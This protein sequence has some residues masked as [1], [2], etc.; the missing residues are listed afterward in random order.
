MY[1]FE[2]AYIYSLLCYLP[3]LSCVP[4]VHAFLLLRIHPSIVWIHLSLSAVDRHL[5]SFQFGTVMNEAAM[6]MNS[7]RTSSEKKIRLR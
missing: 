4:E 6:D 7:T 2:T 1:C 5:D 3:V